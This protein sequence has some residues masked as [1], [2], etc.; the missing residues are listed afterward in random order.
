MKLLTK[1]ELRLD[2]FEKCSA[3][4]D[5]DCPIGQLFDYSCALKAFVIQKMQEAESEAKKVDI[6]SAA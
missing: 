5:A 4:I 1:V 3:L 6:Q 2:G